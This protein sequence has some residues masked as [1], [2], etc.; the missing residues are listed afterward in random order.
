[1]GE[2][3]NETGLRELIANAEA[4]VCPVTK[5]LTLIENFLAGPMCGR[6]FPCSFGSY[7]VRLR[8]RAITE[9]RGTRDDMDALRR[10]ADSMLLSSMC[11]KGKDV[12]D[13]ILLCLDT[14]TFEEH[15]QGQCPDGS[16]RDFM[17]YVIIGEKCII[18]GICK[19]VCKAN[20]IYGE[21]REK[22][23][24]GYLPFEINDKKCN[25]CG[26]C[27]DVCPTGAIEVARSGEDVP[28]KIERS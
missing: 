13:F 25:K 7:E 10:I 18:C 1:M 16:C 12:A 8:L 20:A 19:D 2:N 23:L 17:D 5:S 27:V 15:L 3:T 11:K 6:C 21:K 26:E 28:K 14:S 4:L 24:S 9:A 22:M